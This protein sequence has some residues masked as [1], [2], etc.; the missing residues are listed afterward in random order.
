MYTTRSTF[1]EHNRKFLFP[2]S[3]RSGLL[4]VSCNSC[5]YHAYYHVYR[6]FIQIQHL[7]ALNKAADIVL[8]RQTQLKLC[9]GII[10][11]FNR[12]MRRYQFIFIL[13]I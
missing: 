12:V 5:N 4:A 11:L 9:I 13:N 6:K 1:C 7:I 10:F 2:L 3:W 8:Y